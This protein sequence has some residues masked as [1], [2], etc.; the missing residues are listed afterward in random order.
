MAEDGDPGALFDWLNRRAVV[1]SPLAPGA[2]A[3]GSG[4]QIFTL[5]QPD[6]GHGL[7]AL[8]EDGSPAALAASLTGTDV[9]T[10]GM[11]PAFPGESYQFEVTA[12]PG[13]RL[14]FATMLV[15]SNDWFFAP[16]NA[17]GLRLFRNDGEPREGTVTGQIG[18]FDAGTEVDEVLGFGPNQAP[19]QSGPDTGIDENGVV[20]A[21]DLDV[22][23]YL[24]VTL[25]VI[26]D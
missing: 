17:N 25:E 13:D 18:I 20:H 21:E 7:E 24:K 3:A 16:R 14:D 15:Q 23:R 22:R 5:G 1:A 4:G 2:F 26:D 6:A 19:R 10:F 9:G 11:A 8:A 12:V